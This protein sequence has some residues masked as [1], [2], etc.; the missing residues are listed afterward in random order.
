[1]D[2]KDTEYANVVPM[3]YVVGT[4]LQE[5]FDTSEKTRVYINTDLSGGDAMIDPLLEKKELTIE[6]SAVT[7][8]T[9]SNE[10]KVVSSG[11]KKHVW[12]MNSSGD[13]FH[14]KQGEIGLE[15]E[16]LSGGMKFS[17]FSVAKGGYLFAIGAT[18]QLLYR[19]DPSNNRI[20]RVVEHDLTPFKLVSAVS[21]D[22]AYCI[23]IHGGVMHFDKDKF[24]MMSGNLSKLSVGGPIATGI[25][26]LGGHKLELWGIE[27][28][29]ELL[30]KY[31]EDT[32]TWFRYPFEVQDVACGKD[33]CVYVIRKSDLQLMKLDRD[34]DKFEIQKLKSS[35]GVIRLRNVS[36]Y[37]D[38]KEVY[39]VDYD[40][41]SVIKLFK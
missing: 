35:D 29:S 33:L 37:K 25:F 30:V 20:T 23:N 2:T 17:D 13:L 26:G 12:G 3:G 40:K 36:A 28:D 34:Q 21:Y 41:G 18:D 11:G 6:K 14:A 31:V 38:E 22:S 4:G 8:T 1:L 24:T 15:W 7:S 9:P 32:N 39:A 27:K 5:R 19:L 10:L 16:K